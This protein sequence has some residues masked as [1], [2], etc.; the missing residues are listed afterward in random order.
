MF[1]RKYQLEIY[2]LGT[3]LR[4]EKPFLT[5]R[6]AEGFIRFM[7]ECGGTLPVRIMERS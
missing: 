4:Y 6:G 5:K 1:K 7:H 2:T 3:W